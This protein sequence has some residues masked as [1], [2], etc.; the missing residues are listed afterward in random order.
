M[1]LIEF[2][3]VAS[4]E[5]F[6]RRPREKPRRKRKP[7]LTPDEKRLAKQ[8]ELKRLRQKQRRAAYL[9][10]A[11]R[12]DELKAETERDELTGS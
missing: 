9:L 7:P 11:G 2:P 3:R 4:M 1:R 8:R 12:A 10:G 6:I 5:E